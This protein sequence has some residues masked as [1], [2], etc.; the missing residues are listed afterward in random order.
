MEVHDITPESRFSGD[1]SDCG[2]RLGPYVDDR[3][4]DLRNFKLR[5]LRCGVG[6]L[7]IVV[8]D[9]VADNLDPQLC[10]IHPNDVEAGI[11]TDEENW[12]NLPHSIAEP[13]RTKHRIKTVRNLII[14]HMA[15]KANNDPYD[16]RPQDVVT[17]LLTHARKVV[18]PTQDWMENHPHEPQP[19]G[20][21]FPGKMDHTT[22]VCI[23]VG[24]NL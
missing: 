18:K 24:L 4:P 2:G 16:V 22:C 23:R 11:V 7:L 3:D 9:G 10:G 5:Y 14:K 1:P 21:L 13:L 20:K 8:S 12:D 17:C 6:D 15:M 19:S